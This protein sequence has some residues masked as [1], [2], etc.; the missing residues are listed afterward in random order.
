MWL[1]EDEVG[2]EKGEMARMAMRDPFSNKLPYRAYNESTGEYINCDDTFGYLWECS[3]VAFMPDDYYKRIVIL[4]Q[5]EYPEETV[6][7]FMLYPDDNV[8][9]Q[10]AD[11][12]E[13]KTRKDPVV[14]ESA[15][16]YA[17]HLFSG[18]K[19]LKGMNDIPVRNFR[20]FV[21]VKCP[22]GLN[23]QQVS[24][25]QEC[26][27][28]AG[29]RPRNCPPPQ[30]IAWLRRI[31]NRE[32]PTNPEAYHDGRFICQQIISADDP[33]EEQKNGSVLS[34]GGRLAACLTPKS[35][36]DSIDQLDINSLIGGFMG[37]QD[38]GTQVKNRFLWTTTIFFRT[39]KTAIKSKASLMMGQMA[40]GNLGKALGRRKSENDWVLE[41]VERS[42]YCNVITSLWIFGEDEE[43]L[44]RGVSRVRSL[45]ERK[46]FVMQR[47]SKIAKNMLIAALPFGLYIGRNWFDVILL[48]RDFQMN[49]TSAALLCPVQADFSTPT[50]PVMVFPGRKGQLISLDLF[51]K[52]APNYN[53]LC[54]AGS[55]SGKSF[56][57][58]FLAGNYYGT[59]ALVR[60]MDI[61]HSYKK[62]C[63]SVGGR[64][65]DIGDTSRRMCINPFRARGHDQEDAAGN[66]VATAYIILTMIYSNTGTANLEQT[67]V[68]LVKDAVK[69]ARA[70]DGGLEG[71]NHVYEFLSTYPKYAPEV[72]LQKA[73]QYAHDMAFNLRDWCTSLNGRYGRLFN[74]ESTLDISS[75]EF[76]V[77]ELEELQ[78]NP[79]LFR[80]ISLQVISEITQDLYLNKD[81]SV[82]RFMLFDEAWKYLGKGE[83]SASTNLIANVIEE[84]YRRARKYGGSTGV[85]TQSP[86][87]LP[88]FGPAGNVIKNN[89]AYKM[90][91]MSQDFT[92]AVQKGV[93]NYDGLA[94]ELL[95]SVVNNKPHYSEVFYDTPFG[96]GVGRLC[97]DKFTYWNYTTDPA[98]IP[99]Y[100]AKILAGRT[101]VEALVELSE[102]R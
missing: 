2:L 86:L 65:I 73:I 54:A 69:W 53:L 35:A 62:Q 85:C 58:N 64:F 96:K 10:L 7:Q 51:D 78:N 19:G 88:S 28:G 44:N 97:M 24:Q 16:R 45:W 60:L 21:A 42:P 15:R 25:V 89:S 61:G 80:V 81:R 63:S 4:L 92:E 66:D 34:F 71:V 74:G 95:N 13:L 17:D 82:R 33:L 94:F 43:E 20:L 32:V 8:E 102:G 48:D 11:Y 99:R 83:N 39:S 57:T 1:K 9:P 55:G 6:I 26:L 70:R 5:Q 87:D 18:R 77:F 41:E 49:V 36:P 14:Q 91:L 100:D 40:K 79:E 72:Q 50:K 30:L 37:P 93:L 23:K 3:P 76:V 38:D 22:V 67:Q 12:L 98:E 59:G 75:D 84:G 52:R 46:N 90:W 29:L 47:E 101:P 56:Q 27:E 68:S 31:F